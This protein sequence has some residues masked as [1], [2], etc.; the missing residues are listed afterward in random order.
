MFNLTPLDKRHIFLYLHR[1][2][3]GKQI[4]PP[5]NFNIKSLIREAP[6]DTVAEKLVVF[7]GLIN[8]RDDETPEEGQSNG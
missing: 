1:M 6:S 8:S 7:D 2:L 3:D 4:T 5:L